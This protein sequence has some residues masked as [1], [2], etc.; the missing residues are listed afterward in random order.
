MGTGKTNNKIKHSVSI[1]PCAFN[2]QAAFIH[3]S[4]NGDVR[5]VFHW[6]FWKSIEVDGKYEEFDVD[7]KF[8]LRYSPQENRGKP[9]ITDPQYSFD[10]LLKLPDSGDPAQNPFSTTT[11][12][13]HEIEGKKWGVKLVDGLNATKWKYPETFKKNPFQYVGL[14]TSTYG[15][16][17]AL[18]QVFL[19]NDIKS[20]VS[21]LYGNKIPAILES[22]LL[23]SVFSNPICNNP[24]EVL[25]CTIAAATA[26]SKI[27]KKRVRGPFKLDSSSSDEEDF[28]TIN[29][30]RKKQKSLSSKKT[31][32][33]VD[34]DSD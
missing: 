2:I 11:N 23:E 10:V 4:I 27:N 28:L 13:N 3:K 19:N 29:A 15:E 26:T 18:D 24:S 8:I 25:G 33:L 9:K 21:C 22:N 32:S 7:G 17:A 20:I 16:I 30:N 31:I 34:S 6:D 1:F 12:F 14:D 5:D